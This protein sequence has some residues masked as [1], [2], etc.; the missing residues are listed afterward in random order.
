ML[1]D[2]LEELCKINGEC[3]LNDLAVEIVKIRIRK[4][5]QYEAACT[6]VTNEWK[7]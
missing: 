2:T 6:M 4:L 3:I 1:D 7:G 5:E